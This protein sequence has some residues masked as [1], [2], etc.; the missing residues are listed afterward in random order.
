MFWIISGSV[1][2]GFLL[3]VTFMAVFALAREADGDDLEQ[4]DAAEKSALP[5]SVDQRRVGTGVSR[6]G[7]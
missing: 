6:G 1:F 5:K 7:S 4:A 3:G 2:A